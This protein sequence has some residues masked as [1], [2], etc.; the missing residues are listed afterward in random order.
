MIDE[1]RA[2]VLVGER[3]LGRPA[4]AMQREHELPV[5]ALS[6]RVLLD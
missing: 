6:E 4:G 5:E 3:C 2:I 1:L